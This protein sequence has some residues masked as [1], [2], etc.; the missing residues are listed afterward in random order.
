MVHICNINYQIIIQTVDIL[1]HSKDQTINNDNIINTYNNN[2]QLIQNN[3]IDINDKKV[4]QINSNYSHHEI[5]Y[6]VGKCH[7]INYIELLA[8]PELLSYL[9]NKS[10]TSLNN[11]DIIHL[12][13]DNQQTLN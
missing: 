8:I 3:Q 5:G 13:T 7:D 6:F 10:S 12:I 9:L 1:S 11:I 4:E 2:E